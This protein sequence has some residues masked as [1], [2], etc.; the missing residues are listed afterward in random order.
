MK[1]ST[2]KLVRR[3]KLLIA[4]AAAG[5][6]RSKA[7]ARTPFDQRPP[8]DKI[9]HASRAHWLCVTRATMRGRVHGGKWPDVATQRAA[10]VYAIQAVRDFASMIGANYSNT[11]TAHTWPEWLLA[12]IEA[13]LTSIDVEKSYH[14]ARQARW[15]KYADELEQAALTEGKGSK[16]RQEVRTGPSVDSEA[17]DGLGSR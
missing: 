7:N 17:F 3:M 4:D 14:A 10:I 9:D 1:D 6:V 15:V 12:T 8:E 16:Q 13:A 11:P 2:R 5:S